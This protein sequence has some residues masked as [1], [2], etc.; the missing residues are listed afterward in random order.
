MRGPV[1]HLKA[2]CLSIKVPNISTFMFGLTSGR[3]LAHCLVARPTGRI[4]SSRLL[5]AFASSPSPSAKIEKP[6]IRSPPRPRQPKHASAQHDDSDEITAEIAEKNLQEAK[7]VRHSDTPITL[8][9]YQE[10]AISACVNAL[11]D[12]KKRIGVSSPTGSGK[13]TMFMNLIP[14]IPS[15]NGR[16]QVLILVGSVE[17]AHQAEN[18]ARALLPGHSVE[19]E[20]AKR[21]ASG[22]SDM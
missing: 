10:E 12:G 7:D 21:V 11:N 3:A 13:T 1:L 6:G 4:P 8:R 16:G 9:P 20:Q 15:R 5:R 2:D 19:V 14:R 17:L 18:A 22:T